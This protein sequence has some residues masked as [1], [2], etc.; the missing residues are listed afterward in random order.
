M[1][2][3][4]RNIKADLYEDTSI[5]FTYQI[6]DYSNPTAVKNSFSTSVTLPSTVNNNL[7]FEGAQHP[8]R[9]NHN[10]N[11]SM[12]YD[13]ILKEHGAVTE[14]GYVKLESVSKSESATTYSITL[15]GTLG[16]W[17]YDLKYDS[18]GEEKTLA[19]VFGSELD[20]TIN[21]DTVYAAWSRLH[22]DTSRS[23]LYDTL[24][25]M[26]CYGSP[27]ADNFDPT[28][29]AL[30]VDAYADHIFATSTYTNSNPINV[31]GIN[32]L[33]YDPSG[34][35][36]YSSLGGWVLVK[37]ARDREL[38]AFETNDFRSYLQRPI[39]NLKKVV[40]KIVTASGYTIDWQLAGTGTYALV[41]E[42]PNIWMTLPCLYKI[43]P[44]VKSNDTFT[45]EELLSLTNTP[46]D[47]ILSFIKAYG[48][49]LDVNPFS[50][51]VTIYDR[52]AFYDRES[53]PKELTGTG[54]YT[55]DQL[56][57]D[58]KYFEMRWEDGDTGLETEYTDKYE[59]SWGRQKIDTGYQF[60]Y[61][62]SD[63]FND[64]VFVN[65]I[66]STGQSEFYHMVL[67]STDASTALVYPNIL[68]NNDYW[69]TQLL[70]RS[71]GVNAGYDD[72]YYAP[73]TF[74][75]L[76][77]IPIDNTERIKNTKSL[78]DGRLRYDSTWNVNPLLLIDPVP[79]VCLTDSDGKETDGMNVLVRFNG[80]Q[81]PSVY[82]CIQAG[83][84][85]VYTKVES[86]SSGIYILS[87]DI[88]G[89]YY[90][91]NADGTRPET[92][93]KAES[94]YTWAEL[95]NEGKQCY[96]ATNF[97]EP[98]DVDNVYTCDFGYPQ[99]CR[100]KY[101][102]GSGRTAGKMNCNPLL[103]FGPPSEL[104][105]EKATINNMRGIRD[106]YTLNW[107]SY[108]SDIYNA[109]TRI[110]KMKVKS[111]DIGNPSN[112]T[113]FR[114]FYRFGNALWSLQKVTNYSIGDPLMTC[115]FI[116]VMDKNN[117]V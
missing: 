113:A 50:K 18:E 81:N 58:T 46:A 1:E 98:Q 11:P 39:L 95:Y 47:Y 79:K 35:P 3:Y 105:V 75:L 20:F 54:E 22:G 4:I 115:E 112:I 38:N 49:I 61:S 34:T 91:L 59:K 84:N 30:Y 40:E 70:V 45:T 62:S 106:I 67:T 117:Y 86:T 48:L 111:T 71:S 108:I 16:S 80:F 92:P 41:N 103:C 53:T 110:L 31:H 24:N 102:M 88:E 25:F 94:I 65:A 104:Y 116:R 93:E 82:K 83:R 51:V 52:A 43:R 15:Y 27:S 78:P 12:R 7:I 97:T 57:F 8:C 28:K 9:V 89:T 109:N 6:T 68:G 36:E 107:D 55:L 37:N 73:E 114:K 5:Q 44:E 23:E 100:C 32:D 10:F 101:E 76:M 42:L 26:V 2:L 99:F 90:G 60:E 77:N 14:Q 74:E 69:T 56:N 63:I 33:E 85:Y 87:D 66:D 29:M 72:I 64:M 19:S 21:K 13:F 17:L 96:I